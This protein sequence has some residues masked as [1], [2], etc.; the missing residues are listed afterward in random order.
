MGYAQN[1]IVVSVLMFVYNQEKYLRK[2]IQSIIGQQTDFLYEIIIHDD[3]STDGSAG[4]VEEY[5]IKYPGLIVPILQSENQMQRG[6]S[7]VDEY[8][9]PRVRGK[10]IAFCEGDDYWTRKDKL[11]TQADFLETHEEYAAVSH[12][13]RVVDAN[14]KR[15][16]PVRKFFPYRTPY[17]YTLK[18]LVLEDRMPGQ[19]ATVMYRRRIRTDMSEEEKKDFRRIRYCVGDRRRTL[20]ILLNGPVYC[21]NQTMSAYRY[22]TAGGENWNSRIHGK[23]L[24]GRYY[25]QERDFRRFALKHYGV[26]LRN[27]YIL[28]GTGVMAVVRFL[29]R[30][31]GSSR[32]QLKLVLGEHKS[33]FHFGMFMI[34]AAPSAV[35]TLIIRMIQKAKRL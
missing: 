27:D 10:Y 20:L 15:R 11:Q 34:S 7:I 32:E 19:T 8:I 18:D 33:L 31:D 1:E 17:T 13:C 26:H 3:A 23:N 22:V 28:L 14:G 9:M 4:I 24:A 30:M 35:L 12:N 21:M 25:V 16:E 5:A 2:A 29:K 6:V